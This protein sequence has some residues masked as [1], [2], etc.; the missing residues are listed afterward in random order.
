M[1]SSIYG[2]PLPTHI[3]RELAHYAYTHITT[4]YVVYT[5]LLA[6]EVG[7]HNDPP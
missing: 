7:I 3:H 5:E 1:A 6:N 2:P 4:D